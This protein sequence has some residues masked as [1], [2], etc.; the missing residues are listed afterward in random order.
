MATGPVEGKRNANMDALRLVSMMMVTMLHALAKSDLLPFMGNDVPINGWIAWVFEVFSISAVNIFML[1]SGYFLVTSRFKM[2]RLFEIVLQA[3][4]YL[5][6]ASVIFLLLG[7]ATSESANIYSLLQHF[8]PIHMETYWFI[9]AYVILYMLL[10]LITSGA[11]T[12]SEKQLQ[13]VIVCLLVF[14]CV[15]KSI[16]PFRLTM[17][18]KGYSFL[19]YLILFLVGAKF[20]L[21]GF[22]VVKTAKRGWFVFLI[23]TFLIFAEILVVSQIQTRTGRLKE[24]ATVSLEYNHILVLT[25]A[26][27]I[28]VAFLHAKPCGE[29]FGRLVH[30]ISPYC[31]GV[32][33]LQESL[34]VRYI[35]QDWF[36]L[37]GAM[38]QS[39]PVFL[40]RVLGAVIAMFALG[41]CV[42]VFRS[43]LFKGIANLACR[44]KDKK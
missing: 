26:V 24:I 38:G 11:K 32:Y 34:T 20:R 39:I 23:S 16:L 37:R 42:D 5:A 44:K 36:G 25:A 9:S 3:V 14:E 33:L 29:R 4:F 40:L 43:F 13:G 30:R 18:T 2:G 1:I 6:G 35:W 28:F 7:K 10:P 22:K 19:W 41:I 17:D 31:L 27:G 12:M 8:L 21:Y 15:L